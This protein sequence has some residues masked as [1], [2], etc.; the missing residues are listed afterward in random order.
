MAVNGKDYTITQSP[1]LLASNRSGGTTGAVVWNITP[2]LA[3]WL[4]TESNVLFGNAWLGST[5]TALELG[6][7]ISGLLA[8]SLSPLLEKFI[9]TDQDYVLKVLRRNLDENQRRS[10]PYH[11]SKSKS[12]QPVAP[13]PSDI[14]VMAL[15]WELDS[16]ASLP[17]LLGD[18]PNGKPRTV[19]AVLACDCVY[20]E[21]LIQPFV[22]ACAE[23]C[24][25]HRSQLGADETPTLCI[26]AQQ[27][28]SA[29]VFEEWLVAFHG[30]FHVWRLPDSVLSSDLKTGTG[31]VIHVGTFRDGV[32]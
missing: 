27:L 20:N 25:Q 4:T 32:T 24:R 5:T 12:R 23:I 10:S 28:R 31:Y 11:A 26:I 22:Q 1:T 16:M 3:D 19:G 8:L 18:R 7:G 30:L 14:E 9:A 29:T 2:L 15:D 21:A 6:C 13:S 17:L